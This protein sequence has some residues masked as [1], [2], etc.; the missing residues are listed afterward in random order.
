MP[1]YTLILD[2]N[3]NLFRF[4]ARLLI[5]G[6]CGFFIGIERKSRSKEAGVRTHTVVAL[7]SAVMTIVSKYA[8]SDITTDYDGARIAA[9]IVS[10]MGF[11]GAG[12]IFYKRDSLRGL[13]TAAGLWATAGIGMAIASGLVLTGIVTTTILVIVQ[14][15]L[16]R[17]FRLL[18]NRLVTTLHITVLLE[19]SDTIDEI[20][21]IFNC[22]KF[23]KF[24]TKN[25]DGKTTAYIELITDRVFTEKELYEITNTHSFIK[26]LE[27]TEE[28]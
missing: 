23:L 11:L 27:K 22:Q 17:P 2:A 9:Q 12:I 19:N 4:V 21:A 7:A 25:T 15:L 28:L 1:N 16:H 18:K 3:N 13:T 14:L 26:E 6:L 8:F 24:K 10:G 20:T 5:A